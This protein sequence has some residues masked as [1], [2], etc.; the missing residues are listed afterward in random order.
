MRSS[1]LKRVSL[2]AG[3]VAV[4]TLCAFV[5]VS[6]R[7]ANDDGALR[8]LSASVS[9]NQ[10]TLSVTG[11]GFGPAPVVY[12][13]GIALGS[14]TVN[15]N[16]TALTVPMPTLT[17]GSYSLLV[18]RRARADRDH[19]D[20]IDNN[21]GHRVGTFVLTVG[22]IGP[23][24]P[25]GIPGPQGA[26][27]LQGPQGVPGAPGAEGKQGPPGLPT[28]TVGACGSGICVSDV[29]VNGGT[30]QAHVTPGSTFT[31]SLDYSAVGTGSYCPGCV[32][33]YYVGLSP[34]ATTGHAAGVSA[35]CFINT[36]FGGG[37]QVGSATVTLTAPSQP[38]IYYLAFSL[39]L[40]YSCV[41][42]G[43]LPG[44]APANDQIFGA[45]YVN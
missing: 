7:P 42:S 9:A 21:D 6:A 25:Q 39:S 34:E 14:V 41:G 3:A 45:I 20:D 12:L 37:H 44:G 40:Q 15:A 33:Q 26:Q 4:A 36:V 43:G 19:D 10:S 31:V 17:P 8:V 35:P 18:L 1:P 11:S 2:C 30:H 29:A 32:V 22:A 38:G 16:G 28:L 27:G 23:Q 5:T 13:D 24:G